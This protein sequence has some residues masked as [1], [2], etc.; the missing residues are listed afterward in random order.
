MSALVFDIGLHDGSDTDQYLRAGHRVVAVDANPVMCA[1]AEAKFH[2]CI[3]AGQ[4]KVINCGISEYKD[5]LEFWVCD[6][7]SEW[8]SLDRNLASR[9]GS[10][11]HP[12]LV[13]CVP[14]ADIVD[15]FGVPDY[16]KI[17]IEGHDRICIAGLTSITAPK[18]IS[19]ELDHAHGDQDIKRLFE[20]GYREFKI[21][22]QINAWHQVTTRNMW[23]YDQ[24]EQGRYLPRLWSKLRRAASSMF[25]GRRIGGSGPWGEESSGRWRSV[26]HAQSVWRSLHEFAERFGERGLAGWYDIHAKKQ[27]GTPAN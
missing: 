21:I 22:S 18:Y 4:L 7:N 9:N 15:E 27:P 13:E 26:D 23:F 25:S 6:D 19:I 20:L 8:S 10:K 16:M 14:I 5:Q 1:A 3:R 17:D 12:I 11:H 2:D 24:L